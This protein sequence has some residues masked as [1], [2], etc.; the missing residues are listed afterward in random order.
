MRSAS[1]LISDY[2]KAAFSMAQSLSFE[3]HVQYLDG[4]LGVVGGTPED[5]AVANESKG[6][7]K[8]A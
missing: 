8:A 7:N 3:I 2:F 4:K 6:K 1:H 5:E